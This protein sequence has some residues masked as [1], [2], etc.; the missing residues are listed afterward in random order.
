MAKKKASETFVAALDKGLQ[1][2]REAA[3]SKA[4]EFEEAMTLD[5]GGGG[6]STTTEGADG[7]KTYKI[8]GTVNLCPDGQVITVSAVAG[9]TR[10]KVSCS[11]GSVTVDPNQPELTSD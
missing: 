2:L 11:S 6:A 5:L 7:K 10:G 3:L 9:G 1:L 4:A 8:T